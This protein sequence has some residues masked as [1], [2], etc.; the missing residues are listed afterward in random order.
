MIRVLADL[1][2]NIRSVVDE[3]KKERKRKVTFSEAAENLQDLC[4]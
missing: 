2:R 3:G 1:G 4:C